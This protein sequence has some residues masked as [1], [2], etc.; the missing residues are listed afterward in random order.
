[1]FSLLLIW[2]LDQRQGCC[3][4]NTGR[5]IKKKK[6]KNSGREHGEGIKI[7]GGKRGV[8][9]KYNYFLITRIS[10]YVF[11]MKTKPRAFWTTEEINIINLKITFYF[12]KILTLI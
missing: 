9:K 12:V 5:E 1:M 10:G 2:L 4:I 8:Y 11:M 6:Q 7:K 3:T